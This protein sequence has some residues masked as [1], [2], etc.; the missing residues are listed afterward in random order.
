MTVVCADYFLKP[1]RMYIDKY[2]GHDCGLCRFF[3]W[4]VYVSKWPNVVDMTVVCADSFC[5]MSMHVNSQM[6]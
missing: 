5:G 2:C 4:D 1:L 6:L 3:L